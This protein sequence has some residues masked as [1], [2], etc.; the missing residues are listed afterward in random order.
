MT[1]LVPMGEFTDGGL[2]LPRYRIAI[3]FKP[4]DLLLFDPQEVHGNLPF[5]GKRL[6]LAL[7]CA[8]CIA[9]CGK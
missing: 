5:T 9:D 3:A 1:A 2:V 7:Y 4:G 8:R 6:S